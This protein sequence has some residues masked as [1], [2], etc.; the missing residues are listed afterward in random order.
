MY[1][2]LKNPICKFTP[3]FK[4]DYKKKKDIISASFFK[5]SGGG[6]KNLSI[7]LNG[8]G[9]INDTIDKYILNISLRLFIDY[10]IYNDKKIM[11]ILYKYKHLEMVLCECDKYK[12]T[13][14]YNRG[15]F[16]MFL[17]FFPMFN[18]ENNDAKNIVLSDIDWT[19]T[20]LNN[21]LKIYLKNVKN[22]KIKYDYIWLSNIQLNSIF[23]IDNNIIYPRIYSF[24]MICINKFDN[25]IL[26]D[27]FN[28]KIYNKKTLNNFHKT[29][30][31][32]NTKS[33]KKENKTKNNIFKKKI[34]N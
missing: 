13:N 17:R 7:Y 30:Y 11:E 29:H 9:Y 14:G 3:L 8:I 21:I 20:R 2:Y 28:N 16:G 5:L 6:Y 34:K 15:I 32:T 27:F 10:S 25:N 33:K 26:I 19:H 1:E 12:T 24:N 22:K 4:I 23:K 31:F 18:F